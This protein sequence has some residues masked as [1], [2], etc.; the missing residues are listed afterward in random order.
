MVVLYVESYDYH[1]NLAITGLSL[2]EAEARLYA[3]WKECNRR[4]KREDKR[5]QEAARLAAIY[6][7][8]EEMVY[9]HLWEHG[10]WCE[11]LETVW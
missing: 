3:L 9:T 11:E 4:L 6:N 1:E 8:P 5:R 2:E 7:L 10:I